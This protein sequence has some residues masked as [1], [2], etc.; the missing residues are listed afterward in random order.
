MSDTPLQTFD[1]VPVPPLVPVCQNRPEDRSPDTLRWTI[2]RFDTTFASPWMF[3]DPDDVPED[4]F[5]RDEG[6]ADLVTTHPTRLRQTTLFQNDE[7]CRYGVGTMA[8]DEEGFG[9]GVFCNDPHADGIHQNA[10]G[11][12]VIA[13]AE[14]IAELDPFVNLEEGMAYFAIGYEA[15]P[16]VE[17]HFWSIR[18]K[19]GAVEE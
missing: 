16:V 3:S 13:N 8:L 18:D 19:C 1:P 11:Y 12:P 9:V 2:N 4:I 17:T 5:I 14:Q 15:P 6:F 7:A 10:I